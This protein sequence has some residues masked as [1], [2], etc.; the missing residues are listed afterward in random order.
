MTDFTKK[1]LGNLPDT[2]NVEDYSIEDIAKELPKPLLNSINKA[3]VAPKDSDNRKYCSPLVDQGEQGSCVGQSLGSTL[4]SL[5]KFA[6]GKYVKMSRAYIYWNARQMMGNQYT[7]IDSGA[8]NRLGIKSVVKRGCVEDKD[9]PY[10]EKDFKLA[11]NAIQLTDAMDYQA[12]KYARLDSEPTYNTALVE[13]MKLFLAQGFNIFTGFTVYNY[14]YQLTR[15]NSVLKYP[16]KTDK[17]IGGHAVMLCGHSN[18]I[19][20]NVGQGAFLVQN[21]WGNDHGDRGYFWIPYE[22]F[23]KGVAVDSWIITSMEFLDTGAFK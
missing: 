19:N 16:S 12:L 6:F 13:K 21:S 3:E 10:N 23:S 7:T 20:T 15:K 9:M 11:P 4:E 17:S 14:I 5:Q 2:P 22:Y 1:G 8:M 18:D